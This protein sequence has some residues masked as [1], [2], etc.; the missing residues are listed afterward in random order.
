MRKAPR[1]SLESQGLDLKHYATQLQIENDCRL[2]RKGTQTVGEL[3]CRLF[4]RK[5]MFAGGKTFE[6]RSCF[7]TFL[8]PWNWREVARVSRIE[9]GTL[10]KETL[11]RP[12]RL[13]V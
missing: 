12:A 13:R 11:A 10:D 5:I 4:H 9:R 1:L 8:T 6:C 3:W 2:N 7:R